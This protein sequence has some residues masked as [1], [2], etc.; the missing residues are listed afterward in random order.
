MW[1]PAAGGGSFGGAHEVV[2]KVFHVLRI[3]RNILVRPPSAPKLSRTT[4]RLQVEK[5]RRTTAWIRTFAFVNFSSSSGARDTSGGVGLGSTPAPFRKVLLVKE[6]KSREARTTG[7]GAHRLRRRL[8]RAVPTRSGEGSD[9][10]G[11]TI[12]R[13]LEETRLPAGG[14]PAHTLCYAHSPTQR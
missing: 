12:D 13:R 8:A 3:F 1:P 9:E 11:A 2:K 7:C 5:K 14:D 10:A 6:F 4:S